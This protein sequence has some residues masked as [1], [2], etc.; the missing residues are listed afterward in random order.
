VSLIES[1]DLTSHTSARHRTEIHLTRPE[2]QSD[3]TG[4]ADEK[5]A[6]DDPKVDDSVGSPLKDVSPGAPEHSPVGA[7]ISAKP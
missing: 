4:F 3:A 5:P 2:S 7:V 1:A 6:S